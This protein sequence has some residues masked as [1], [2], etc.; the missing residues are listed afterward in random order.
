ML[1]SSKSPNDIPLQEAQWFSLLRSEQESQC[2]QALVWS[3][4]RMG[5]TAQQRELYFSGV[6]CND[7][8]N[9]TTEQSKNYWDDDKGCKGDYATKQLLPIAMRASLIFENEGKDDEC[10][11]ATKWVLAVQVIYSM[12]VNRLLLQLLCIVQR[13][14]SVA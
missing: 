10:D 14:A 1:D 8:M 6:K 12:Y 3:T 13:N 5:T 2:L 7:A 11:N 4:F 9:A